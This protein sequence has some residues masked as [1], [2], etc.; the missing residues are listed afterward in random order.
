[1]TTSDALSRLA[2]GLTEEDAA[3]SAVRHGEWRHVIRNGTSE[4]LDSDN[5]M[6]SYTQYDMV[7][8]EHIARQDPATTLRRVQAIRRATAEAQGILEAVSDDGRFVLVVNSVE[9][10]LRELASIYTD[11]ETEGTPCSD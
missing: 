10:I 11:D 8:N 2:A 1:M 5:D 6:V 4:V 9:A 7:T 3:A